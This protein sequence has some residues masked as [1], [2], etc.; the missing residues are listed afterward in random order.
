MSTKEERTETT[1]LPKVSTPVEFRT[2]NGFAILRRCE[3]DPA[4]VDSTAGCHF[5]VRDPTA[6]EF[7]VTVVYNTETIELIQKQTARLVSSSVSFWLE[8]AE[9]TL[10]RYLWQTDNPPPD[11]WLVIHALPPTDLMLAASWNC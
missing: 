10:A 4:V 8:C 7:A 1:T 5:L 2:E 3:L 6:R 11:G 9:R